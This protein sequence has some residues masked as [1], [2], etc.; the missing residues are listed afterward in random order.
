[1]TQLMAPKPY[2]AQAVFTA[3]R[4]TALRK[5]VAEC[6][7]GVFTSCGAQLKD[8]RP[9]AET[10]DLSYRLLHRD[11][12]LSELKISHMTPSRKWALEDLNVAYPRD[13]LIE[14]E[15]EGVFKKL[16][17]SAVSMVGSITLVHGAFERC[18]AADQARIRPAGSRPGADR[19]VLTAMPS[20]RG[21]DRKRTGSE[22]FADRE[23]EHRMGHHS[24]GKTAA[25]MLPGFPDRLSGRQ[26]GHAGIAAANT[27]SG[28]L[29]RRRNL[30]VIGRCMSCPSS[31]RRMAAVIGRKS[32]RISTGE[33]SAR[34]RRML[35]I[36]AVAVRR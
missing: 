14:L 9:L 35:R 22:R 7:L 26:A 17:P 11:V 23:P 18:C 25:A 32:S 36:I 12:A 16:A 15:A 29:P 30:P 33:A 2:P 8:D 3:P 5:P 28:L 20:V 10:N 6:T 1:M 31:G 24:G 19:A 13:R 21:T 34:W 4:I 27:E